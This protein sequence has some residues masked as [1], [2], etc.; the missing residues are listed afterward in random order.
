MSYTHFTLEERESLALFLAEG[1]TQSQIARELGRHRSTIKREIERNYSKCKKRYNP[2]RATICYIVRR[3]R[4]V[5]RPV[6]TKGSELYNFILSGLQVFWPPEVIVQRGRE[7]GYN[8]SCS[9]IYRAIRKGVF[10]KF[11]AKKYLRRRG[12]IVIFPIKIPMLYILFTPFMIVLPS[13]KQ[14]NALVIGKAIRCMERLEEA[15]L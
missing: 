2:I 5:R 12:K 13:S 11:A 15:A 4:C 14:R 9:T 8:I 1:K 6:I 10:G 7:E 3:K